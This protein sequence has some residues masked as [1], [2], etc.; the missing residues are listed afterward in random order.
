MTWNVTLHASALLTIYS[1]VGKIS[2]RSDSASFIFVVL[3]SLIHSVFVLP[4]PQQHI[5]IPRQNVKS[6]D[7]MCHEEKISRSGI[8][9]IVHGFLF[10]CWFF[11]CISSWTK[12]STVHAIRDTSN[13]HKLFEL[14][15]ILTQITFYAVYALPS[16]DISWGINSCKAITICCTIWK[17][18]TF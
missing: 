8:E 15:L 16:K 13:K 5:V 4:M 7:R 11:F 18:N 12:N 14:G 6:S 9:F 2:N 1:K 3:Y 10:Y 17:N